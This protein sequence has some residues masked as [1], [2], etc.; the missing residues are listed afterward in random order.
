MFVTIILRRIAA[1]MRYRAH[2]REL[3]ELTDRDLTDIGLSR[4]NLEHTARMGDERSPFRG[5]S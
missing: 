2:L 3:G 4:G 5:R 1:W